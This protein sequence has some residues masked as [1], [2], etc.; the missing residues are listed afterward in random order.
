M[1]HIFIS[2]VGE[3]EALAVELAQRLEA[4]GYATW[5][6]ERDSLP[7]ASYLLQ[8]GQAVED[9]AAVVVII[10]PNSVES[11]QVTKEVVRAHE[12]AKPFIPILH[13][14]THAEFQRR[15]PEWR[16]AMGSAASVQL[17]SEGVAAMLPRLVGGLTALKI[18][19]A[20]G[21]G[22]ST[23]LAVARPA[24]PAQPPAASGGT[25]RRWLMIGGAAVVLAA[26]VAALWFRPAA[27]RELPAPVVEPLSA[28][29]Q[30]LPKAVEEQS[31]PPARRESDDAAAKKNS[32]RGRVTA[33]RTA[34]KKAPRCNPLIPH[35]SQPGCREN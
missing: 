8:T 21:K 6:Y 11:N 10:T 19:A 16:E 17:P 33:R 35:Y 15:Q 34:G 13:G 22:S 1:S 7:G 20:G 9:A 23:P 29:S 31:L 14:I 25:D 24:S 4:A 12:G 18:P 28:A 26:A 3:D 30:E 32:R 2:H 27:R 5:Y